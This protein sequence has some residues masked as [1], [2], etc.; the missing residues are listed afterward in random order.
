M[1]S[2]F[3]DLKC[4]NSF[5]CILPS[6]ASST[7]GEDDR[8]QIRSASASRSSSCRRDCRAHASGRR[9]QRRLKLKAFASVERRRRRSRF[10]CCFCKLTAF[11]GYALGRGGGAK[12]R[13]RKENDG[14]KLHDRESGDGRWLV[15]ADSSNASIAHKR[16]LKYARKPTHISRSALV[17]NY[18]SA[19]SRRQA[20]KAGLRA[21]RRPQAAA[22][23]TARAQIFLHLSGHES[24]AALFW[25]FR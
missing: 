21:R 6:A 14:E 5:Y 18:N 20:E 25:P 1:H 2:T 8:I 9:P 10:C 4:F 16:L 17:T 7:D 23:Q 24:K 19:D 11:C 22:A 12:K 15:G 3:F 13:E